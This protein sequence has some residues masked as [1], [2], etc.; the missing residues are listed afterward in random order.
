M[1][2]GA[3]DEFARAPLITRVWDSEDTLFALADRTA[4]GSHDGGAS[5][6]ELAK[7]L[8]SRATVLVGAL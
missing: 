4:W 5:W 1:A 3:R 8:P 6:I 7:D 2:L